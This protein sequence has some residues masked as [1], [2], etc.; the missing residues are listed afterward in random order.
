MNHPS[1]WARFFDEN[2]G[3]YQYK[4]N[5][6]GVVRDAFM[7]IG[8]A[9]TGAVKTAATKLAKVIAKKAGQRVGGIVVEKGSKHIQDIVRKRKSQVSPD[10][11]KKLGNIMQPQAS[12]LN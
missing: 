1:E 6:S 5:G 7:A 11:R 4:H 9:F 8:R 12:K 3:R 2:T 10:A